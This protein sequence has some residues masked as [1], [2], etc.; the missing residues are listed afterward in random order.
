MLESNAGL[1]E[2][3]MKEPVGRAN[4]NARRSRE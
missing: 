4:C 1:K 3:V 2:Q